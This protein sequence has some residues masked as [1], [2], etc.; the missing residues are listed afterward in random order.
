MTSNPGFIFMGDV[1]AV[2]YLIY[3]QWIQSSKVQSKKY[4]KMVTRIDSN[5]IWFTARERRVSKSLSS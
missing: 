2:K 4:Y 1:T 5:K 3:S